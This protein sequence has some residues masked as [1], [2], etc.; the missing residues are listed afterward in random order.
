MKGYASTAAQVAS[1][2]PFVLTANM[3][4]VHGPHSATAANSASA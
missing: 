1:N 3:S 2:T 4:V